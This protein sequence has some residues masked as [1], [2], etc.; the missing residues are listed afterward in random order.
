MNS[1]SFTQ[2]LVLIAIPLAVAL[3]VFTESAGGARLVDPPSGQTNVA[4]EQYVVNEEGNLTL[5]PAEFDGVIAMSD[6][7]VAVD[8]WA[9]WCGWCKA[10]EPELEQV[11]VEMQDQV[12]IV[13]INVDENPE[14]AQHFQI[15]GIPDVRFF[16]NGKAVDSCAYEKADSII[17]RIEAVRTGE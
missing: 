9:H 14:L 3:Y 7:V 13:R 6:K 11:A 5:Q 1:S 8:F 16:R 17:A 15:G 4:V 10:L 2:T 12:V